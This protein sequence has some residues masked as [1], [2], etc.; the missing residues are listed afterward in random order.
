MAGKPAFAQ[1]LLSGQ[2][3]AT[4]FCTGYRNKI[5]LRCQH[6]N[7]DFTNEETETQEIKDPVRGWTCSSTEVSQSGHG[8][9]TWKLWH[10]SEASVASATSAPT[11]QG[12]SGQDQAGIQ[13][14]GKVAHQGRKQDR[15][16]SSHKCHLSTEITRLLR[17]PEK[18]QNEIDEKTE[19]PGIKT[20]LLQARQSFTLV[21][22]AGVQRHNLGSPQTLPP[23]FN[24]NYRHAAPHPPNFVFLVETRFLQVGQAGLKLPTLGDSSASASHSAGITGVSH[25]TW[26]KMFSLE[27]KQEY[28]EKHRPGRVVHTYNPNTLGGQGMWTT[29]TQVFET[30]LDGVLLCGLGWSATVRSPL[31]ATSASWVQANLLF[32]LLSSWNYKRPIPR[33]A[34]FVVLV[35]T[36]FHH[37]FALSPRLERSGAILA[38]GKLHLPGS[39]DPPTSASQVAGTT[40]AHDHNQLI[41]VFLVEMWSCYVAQASLELLSSGDP[42]TLASRRAGTTGSH[43]VPPQLL[44]IVLSS[45]SISEQL[46][47]YGM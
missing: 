35:D 9:L 2:H 41:F 5:T 12:L 6:L 27:T 23:R 38:Y 7:Y 31:T 10:S 30:S 14:E 21:A 32:S 19:T 25:R 42:P 11:P 17:V 13:M 28:F 33:P 16:E 1:C 18:G 44:L 36:G 15:V 20:S 4:L 40:A 24:W 37:S 43:R 3:C 8:L 22:Q 26:P 29:Q 39:S 34:H 46:S 47:R 45:P